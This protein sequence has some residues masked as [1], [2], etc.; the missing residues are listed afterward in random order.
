MFSHPDFVKSFGL[1]SGCSLQ[2]LFVSYFLFIFVFGEPHIYKSHAFSLQIFVFQVL[3]I[4][5]CKVLWKASYMIPYYH[6]YFLS[7]FYFMKW[8]T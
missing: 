6:L 5:I 3:K 1:S 8:R 7:T 4:S 2:S